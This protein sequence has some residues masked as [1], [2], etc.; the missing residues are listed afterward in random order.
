MRRHDNRLRMTVTLAATA[1]AVAACGGGGG[2]GDDDDQPAPNSAP[3][4][5]SI[6]DRSVDQD[7]S[8]TGLSF[9]V[10]DAESGAG[11]LAVTVSSADETILP[12]GSLVLG[13]SGG[14]RTLAMTPA[15]S[16]FGTA[17]VTVS[18]SDGQ[19]NVS[20]DFNWT[21]RPVFRSF[22]NHTL[23]TFGITQDEVAGNMVGFTLDSDADDLD[24]PFDALLQ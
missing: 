11:S 3:T 18:V 9:T 22:T 10:A 15:E 1:L 16:A 5:S 2:Y 6:G 14:T 17:I 4:I 8:D 24:A 13:G 7:L 20:R 21:V 19:V 12:V 23:N